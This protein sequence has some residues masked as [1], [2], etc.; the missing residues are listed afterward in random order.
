MRIIREILN[1]E[2]AGKK[3]SIND[4]LVYLNKVIK[5][6]AIIF[7]ISDFIDK[8]FSKT[9]KISSKKHD[10]ISINISDLREVSIP[11]KGAFILRD[12]ESGEEFFID[13]S[14]KKI[15]QSFNYFVKRN[16]LYLSELFKKYKVDSINIK[17]EENY[18]K[19]LF[20]FFIERKK[21]FVR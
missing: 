11:E 15:K 14:S 4:G 21:K 19:P 7:L 3:T 18:E 8:D 12:H 16:D 1:F 2:P 5:K 20:D 6:K 10:L 17:D 9:L 13:F